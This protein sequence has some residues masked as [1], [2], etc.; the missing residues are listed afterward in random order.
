[1]ANAGQFFAALSRRKSIVAD[2][3]AGSA[4]DS[5]AALR[6]VLGFWSLVAIGIGCTIGAGIFVLP[7]VVAAQTAGPGILISFLLAGLACAIAAFC[8]AELAVLIPAAGSA[9]SYAY[10]TLGE[11][12][13]WLVGWNL[14][15]EYGLSNSAV[16]AGW[17]GYVQALLRGMGLSLPPAWMVATGQPIPATVYEAAGLAVPLG[18][19]F[20]WLNLP[21]AIAVALPTILLLV[22]IRASAQ[23][24]NG[25]VAAKIG[26][27][28]MFVMLCLP[29]VQATHFTPFLPFGASGVVTGAA[30]LFFLFIGFDAVSTVAE[31]CENPQRDVPRAM[32]VGLGLV[33]TLYIAVTA[34]L[35]GVVPLNVLKS[36]QEPLARALDLAGH[37]IA[38]MLLSCV[39]VV[40]VLAVILVASI[41][42]TR[43]LFVMA[44]DGLMPAL[45]GR[46]SAGRGVP[47]TATI[48][49]GVVTGGLAATVPLDALADL[50]S[51]GTLAAFTAVSL[52]VLVLRWERPDLPRPFR[53]PF[54]P[55]LPLA[56]IAVNLWLMS[57]LPAAV[58]IRFAV[59]MALGI[60]IYLLW[61][62]RGASRRFE[63][64]PP[65]E[66][67]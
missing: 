36:A 60:A 8:Y 28:L 23:F 54:S 58:W 3:S 64:R 56:G 62:M 16:A 19:T 59:W 31:E 66:V 2:R 25:L 5:P 24:N 9:Y 53:V 11:G 21:A 63:T 4:P 15:L 52:G 20:G 7:G 45:M 46:V 34:V 37:P 17:G 48:L 33:A 55:E 6:R 13:A 27:L 14:L 1:M 49:L 42:Q 67:A 22:G 12:V 50:V 40:G 35:L 44:R 51:I 10:A 57:S 30:V 39:A 47:V 26:V 18:P 61:G 65:E 29:A 32:M 43:I 38:A 41:G